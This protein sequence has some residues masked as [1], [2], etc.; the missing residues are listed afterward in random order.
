[1]P[2]QKSTRGRSKKDWMEGIWKAMNEIDL[3]KG[4][5]EDR[6]QWCLCVGQRRKAF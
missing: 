3:S 4:Q 5:W 2:K 1:M 6:K